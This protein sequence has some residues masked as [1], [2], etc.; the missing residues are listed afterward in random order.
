MDF[1]QHCFIC[2]PSNSTVLE[3][4]EIETRTVATSAR[5]H[6]QGWTL[7]VGTVNHTL[8][9]SNPLDIILSASIIYFFH[10]FRGGGDL[11]SFT[12]RDMW[13]SGGSFYHLFKKYRG[14]ISWDVTRGGAELVSCCCCTNL[15]SVFSKNQQMVDVRKKS[16]E[17]IRP[18]G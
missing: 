5:S 16:D 12:G 10:F 14:I 4:D 13:L 1:I 2:R 15:S 3:E 18:S 6:P 11:I 9:L 17:H 8:L 7:L